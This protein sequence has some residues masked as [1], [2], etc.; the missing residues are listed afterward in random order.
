MEKS[1][2]VSVKP[3]QRLA[4]SRGR[5]LVALRKARNTLN[6]KL[7]TALT[8]KEKILHQAQEGRNEEKCG[9]FFL[10]PWETLAGGFPIK[11]ADTF[12]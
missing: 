1:M 4:G 6:L 10:V 12:L 8:A 9:A 2:K 5:A 7:L 3:F 11:R